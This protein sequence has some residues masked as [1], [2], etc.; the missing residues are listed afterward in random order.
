MLQS[1]EHSRTYGRG[2]T[3]FREDITCKKKLSVSNNVKKRPSSSSIDSYV[4]LG[5]NYSRPNSTSLTSSSGTPISVHLCPKFRDPH[6]HPHRSY[7]NKYQTQKFFTSSKSSS[8]TAK[9]KIDRDQL[10]VSINEIAELIEDAGSRNST[11][12]ESYSVG[13]TAS[14]K[15]CE[16]SEKPVGLLNTKNEWNDHSK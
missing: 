13:S 2:N 5:S 1:Q 7:Q 10:R 3:D 15:N 4:S 8:S 9:K 11:L 14:E 16:N 12:G 6:H